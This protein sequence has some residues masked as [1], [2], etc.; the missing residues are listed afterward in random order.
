MRYDIWM[1]L[2][3]F[4]YDTWAHIRRDQRYP[5][6]QL[7]P[8]RRESYDAEWGLRDN[9]LNCAGPERS[10]AA[11]VFDEWNGYNQQK[12]RTG[13]KDAATHHRERRK[14]GF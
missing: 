5:I 6:A 1:N 2:K 9:V 8:V 7:I 4:S 12:W 10:E 13:V 3:F 11:K 14:A